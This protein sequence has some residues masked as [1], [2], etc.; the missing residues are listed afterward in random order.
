MKRKITNT[1][2][3]AYSNPIIGFVNALNIPAQESRGQRELVNSCQMPAKNNSYGSN[4]RSVT[5]QYKLMGIKVSETQDKNDD[6]FLEVEL[7]E[8]WKK[9]ATDH[10]MWSNLLDH[11]GR[12]RASIFYKGAFYDRDAFINFETRYSY[13]V[14]TFLPQDQCGHFEMQEVKVEVENPANRYFADHYG[15]REFMYEMRSKKGKKFF[16]TKQEK[17]WVPKFKDDYEKYN[18]TPMYYEILDGDKVLFSTK[19]K[20]YFFTEKYY[21]DIH[22]A[23]WDR[24]HVFQD[25]LKMNA[26]LYMAEHF[27]LYQDI[28]A[29]WD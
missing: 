18:N 24:L 11:K 4:K 19:D 21:K 13:S 5:D 14:V 28:N 8:G 7:P 17:V 25:Q 12:R 22:S 9:E 1:A 10:S 29:Y 23:W 16:T 3:E 27:P 6:L 20:P 26:Q 15:D 2:K